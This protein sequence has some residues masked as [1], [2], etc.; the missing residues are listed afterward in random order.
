V[1]EW[2]DADDPFDGGSEMDDHDLQ[3]RLTEVLG[4]GDKATGQERE[5]REQVKKWIKEQGRP[6]FDRLVLILNEVGAEVGTDRWEDYTGMVSFVRAGH[7]FTYLID[8]TV[9]PKGITG[10]THIKAPGQ[11]E[12]THGPVEHIVK[13]TQDHIVE[14]FVKGLDSWHPERK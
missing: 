3:S 9:S 2:G 13:W 14:D 11:E 5:H 12:R 10:T 8:L 4:R 6:A 1:R 7:E